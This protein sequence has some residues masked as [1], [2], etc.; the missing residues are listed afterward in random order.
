MTVRATN[1][2]NQED[3]VLSCVVIP[4]S[5]FV[6]LAEMEQSTPCRFLSIF[7]PEPHLWAGT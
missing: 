1:L 5:S 7:S 4:S 6:L 2:I 3:Q